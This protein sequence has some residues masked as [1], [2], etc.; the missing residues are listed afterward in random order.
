MVNLFLKYLEL[1]N[2]N[3]VAFDPQNTLWEGVT[4]NEETALERLKQFAQGHMANK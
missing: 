3:I 1:H 2:T 4:R